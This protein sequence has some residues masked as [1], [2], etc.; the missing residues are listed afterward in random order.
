VEESARRKHRS[1]KSRA[2]DIAGGGVRLG[3]GSGGGGGGGGG[4][5]TCQ[6]KKRPTHGKGGAPPQCLAVGVC[7]TASDIVPL[8][9]RRTHLVLHSKCAA[10][11]FVRRRF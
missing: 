7:T 3:R 8:A 10:F 6:L 1:E 4:A 5:G 11:A 2:C 9:G